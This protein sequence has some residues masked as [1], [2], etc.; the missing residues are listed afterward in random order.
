MVPRMASSRIRRAL[1]PS[2]LIAPLLLVG[3]AEAHRPAFPLAIPPRAR[4]ARG[5]PSP[6]YRDW[7]GREKKDLRTR[8]IE[9]AVRRAGGWARWRQLESLVL[10]SRR[11]SLSPLGRVQDNQEETWIYRP[12]SLARYWQEDNVLHSAVLEGRSLKLVEPALPRG[13]PEAVAL[14]ADLE[15]AQFWM[16]HPFLLYRP[17]L[18]TRYL[19]T[20][21]SRG[22]WGHLLLARFDPGAG[23]YREVEYLFD[24]RRGDLLRAIARPS[25]VD[26]PEE[27]HHFR[28]RVTGPEG[29][30]IPRTHEVLID[31]VVR[32][33]TVVHDVATDAPV[34]HPAALSPE[35]RALASRRHR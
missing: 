23:P 21:T 34:L 31:G 27:V 22:A 2:L 14:Q 8:L 35:G 11:R 19:G 12:E 6:V 3:E 30:R 20:T 4:A 24:P 18:R 9:H 29:L 16:A 5:T 10:R 28:G 17:G 1:A 32:Q 13:A 7:G 33:V 25:R 26:E 15:R